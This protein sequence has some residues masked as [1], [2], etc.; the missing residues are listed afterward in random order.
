M[1]ALGKELSEKLR[2]DRFPGNWTGYKTGECID[3][4]APNQ[5]RRENPSN[6]FPVE[7]SG[8]F[9]LSQQKG[10]AQQDEQMDTG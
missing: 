10:S 7:N 3:H 6:S 9:F 4:Q 8:G 2:N 1:N 5:E